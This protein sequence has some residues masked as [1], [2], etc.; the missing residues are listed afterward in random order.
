MVRTIVIIWAALIGGLLLLFGV[1]IAAYLLADPNKQFYSQRFYPIPSQTEL[2][3][4]GEY[5]ILE[6]RHHTQ[7]DR[8]NPVYSKGGDPV[9][10]LFFIDLS[11]P[12]LTYWVGREASP[13][14][15]ADRSEVLQVGGK[16]PE[17]LRILPDGT[18]A[19]SVYPEAI[20]QRLTAYKFF[21]SALS[22]DGTTLAHTSRDTHA[23]VFI[24]PLADPT[25][26]EI[27]SDFPHP[28]QALIWSQ[29]G[30][31]LFFATCESE[32]QTRLY[33]VNMDGTNLKLLTAE[34]QPAN[35]SKYSPTVRNMTQ[36]P[37]GILLYVYGEVS[38]GAAQKPQTIV[39]LN[40]DT[41]QRQPLET[42]QSK[43]ATL[44]LLNDG[45]T[46][47]YLQEGKLYR[48]PLRNDGS[49]ELIFAHHDGTILEFVESP[50]GEKFA[51]KV[52]LNTESI[53]VN[54]SDTWRPGMGG[55]VQFHNAQIW[56]V[57]ADSTGSQLLIDRHVAPKLIAWYRHP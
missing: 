32:Q 48:R 11:Q 38:Y 4:P 57:N 10:G 30:R 19:L 15:F 23:P 49:A 39:Q 9:D 45:Q 26:E 25:A 21:T 40:P 47:A 17:L 14:A 56:M 55:Q 22:A 36:L 34:P 18:F 33:Q 16:F 20:N 53:R 31:S 51:Y 52:A 3:A 41:G 13:T 1:A 43:F 44:K 46:L 5:L 27:L 2:P 42:I 35:C 29:D 6:G 24:Q 28:I 37:D 50:D 54:P 12:E 7:R 8:R